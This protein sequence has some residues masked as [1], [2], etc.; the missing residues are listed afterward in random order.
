MGNGVSSISNSSDVSS[1]N[2]DMSG[3]LYATKQRKLME[4]ARALRDKGY[5]VFSVSSPEL[6]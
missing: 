5:V 4:I 2:D 1:S 6:V 3:T